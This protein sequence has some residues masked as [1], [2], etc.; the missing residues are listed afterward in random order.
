[1]IFPELFPRYFHPELSIYYNASLLMSE[2]K[3]T[4]R[5]DIIDLFQ[6]AKELNNMTFSTLLLCLDWL[7][8]IDF[9]YVDD[10]GEVI[11]CSLK[12]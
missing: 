4:P 7:Y 11:L 1:M 9:A 5:M 10:K 8:L 12:A 3:T 6:R 2:I